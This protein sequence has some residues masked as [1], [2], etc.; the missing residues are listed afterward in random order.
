MYRW[1]KRALVV[2]IVLSPGA[3]AWGEPNKETA[4]A[5]RIAAVAAVG[6]DRMSCHCGHGI[7]VEASHPA[8]V[9]VLP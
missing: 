8:R 9:R 7:P 6:G 3:L 2:L 1:I 4:D 5:D